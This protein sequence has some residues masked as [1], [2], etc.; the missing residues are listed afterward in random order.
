M[1]LANLYSTGGYAQSWGIYGE[2]MDQ[3]LSSQ[4]IT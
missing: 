2:Q 4:D 3:E 1:L